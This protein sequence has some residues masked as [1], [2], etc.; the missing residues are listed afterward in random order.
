MD[1]SY[2]HL[3]H[4]FREFL[5]KILCWVLRIK[6]TEDKNLNVPRV[7]NLSQ[8]NNNEII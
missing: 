1:R 4:A 2:Q 8:G 5:K 3:L 7:D 6:M